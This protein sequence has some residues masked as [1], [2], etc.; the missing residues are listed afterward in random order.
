MKTVRIVRYVQMAALSLIT[1]LSFAQT[2]AG[3]TNSAGGALNDAG[4]WY[5]NTPAPGVEMKF[6][7]N[8]PGNNL[9]PNGLTIPLTLNANLT[10]KRWSCGWGW[11]V[12]DLNLSGF[13]LFL[14]DPDAW[15]SSPAWWLNTSSQNSTNTITGTGTVWGADFSVGA[16]A[17]SSG[18]LDVYG[19]STRMA[20]TGNVSDC[21]LNG[22][23]VDSAP[24]NAGSWFRVRGGATVTNGAH[25]VLVGSSDKTHGGIY[26]SDTGTV[27][28]CPPAVGGAFFGGYGSHTVSN[29]AIGDLVV[30][31]G[32]KWSGA[33]IYFG[34][35]SG[36]IGNGKVTGAGS[37]LVAPGCRIWIGG[38]GKGLLIIENGGSG[39]TPEGTW[40]GRGN[41]GGAGF[42]A[43]AVGEVRVVGANSSYSAGYW[44]ALVGNQATGLVYVSSGGSFI[45]T[46]NGEG[47][48]LGMGGEFSSTNT[49]AYGLFSVS[50]ANSLGT[51]RRVEIGRYGKGKVE[52]MDEA[53]L[54]V[55]GAGADGYLKLRDGGNLTISDAEVTANGDLTS[56]GACTVRIELGARNHASNY[57][58]VANLNLSSG[59]PTL[60]VGVASD[61]SAEHMETIKLI[62]CTT[63]RTGFFANR[64][65]QSTFTS[66]SYNFRITYS[67]NSVYLTVL[68]LGTVVTVR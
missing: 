60:D 37:T 12:Y 50:N 7:E 55:T 44:G 62:G 15:D 64:A 32:A 24:F 57:L 43:S 56:E 8:G 30:S 41:L 42:S 6:Y 51:I 19:S 53:K 23:N 1:T 67:A 21:Y 10:A 54:N 29:E 27:W 39:S 26:L 33:T 9:P 48:V 65:D 28:Y 58:S 4:N 20:F 14:D 16:G 31:N 22:V 45:A 63:G 11:H 35:E 61:F 13:D 25:S 46:G 52:V 40:I 3:W 5:G 47:M 18:L 68:R 66:G 17:N 38:K 59:T 34:R 36:C 2:P 49:A